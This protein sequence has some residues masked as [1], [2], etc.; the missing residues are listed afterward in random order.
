MPSLR[1]VSSSEQ[2]EAL[3]SRDAERDEEPHGVDL[4]IMPYIRDVSLWPVL[5]VLIV[6]VVAFVTPVLLYAIRDSRTG[7]IFAIGI[8]VLLSLRGIYWEIRSR[9]TF[10]AI[11]WLIVVSWVS[12][13]VAA[14]FANLH[15]FL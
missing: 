8:V 7:P 13:F 10:G 9:K 1:G 14:Y 15:D 4:W 3:A 11:S 5:V 12:S 6:H 2:T